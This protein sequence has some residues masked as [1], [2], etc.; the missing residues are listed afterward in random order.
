MDLGT[1]QQVFTDG[2]CI[3]VDVLCSSSWK[4]VQSLESPRLQHLA[5]GLISS[6][7]RGK[8]PA[9][10]MKYLGGFRRWK[11]WALDHKLQIFPANESHVVLY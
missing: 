2:L 3:F 10:T 5:D 9:I 1:I 8:A 7:L 4:S 11:T 6:A